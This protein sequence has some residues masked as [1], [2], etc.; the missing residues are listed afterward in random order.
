MDV[1]TRAHDD[2]YLPDSFA[3]HPQRVAAG[4][5]HNIQTG[6]SSKTRSLY[7]CTAS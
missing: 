5:D 3:S 6:H 1:H 2:S 4:A 7:A